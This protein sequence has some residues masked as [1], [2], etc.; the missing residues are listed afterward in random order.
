MGT[1]W[2][3]D[4]VRWARRPGSYVCATWHFL[5]G[6]RGK[7]RG[8]LQPLIW[9]CLLETG[10]LRKAFC[11]VWCSGNRGRGRLQVVGQYREAMVGSSSK[12]GQPGQ[13]QELGMGRMCPRSD[14]NH[15]SWTLF[16]QSAESRPWGLSRC[17]T[18]QP[19]SHPQHPSFSHLDLATPRSLG[20][21]DQPRSITMRNITSQPCCPHWI[22]F[23]ILTRSLGD[24]HALMF[25]KPG[26]GAL[27]QESSLGH[28]PP[29]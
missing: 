19:L 26:H 20:L 8:G 4:K 18:P 15:R 14:A 24:S 3:G 2:D 27:N 1:R 12:R 11:R 25:E 28:W 10:F 23:S 5:T 17:P 6:A 13:C 22:C 9:S 29:E 16:P 21:L 7:K